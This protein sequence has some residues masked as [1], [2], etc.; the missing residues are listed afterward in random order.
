MRA[1]TPTSDDDSR[2]SGIRARSGAPAA[3]AHAAGPGAGG[4]APLQRAVGN[5]VVARMLQRAR[6]SS[7]HEVLRSPG[8]PLAG[9]V[10]QEME[11][12]LGADFSDVRVHTGSAA[13]ASAAEVGARAYTS[14]SHIVLGDGG[15]DRH[16]LA[17]E[18]THVVQQ[19]QGPVEGTDNGAGL[20]ISDPGDRFER[21]A[22]ANA[23]RVLAGPV[24]S[25]GDAPEHPARQDR[26]DRFPALQRKKNEKKQGP[27]GAPETQLYNVFF[28][29]VDQAV[30]WAYRYVTTAPQL[31]P[32]ADYDGHT[33]HWVEVWREFHATG[34]SGGVSKEFGYAVESVADAY[35]NGAGRPSLPGDAEFRSQVTFGTTRPDYVLYQRGQ[36]VGA[37]DVTATGSKDHTDDKTRWNELF[38]QHGESL[39]DSLDTNVRAGMALAHDNEAPLTQQEADALVQQAAEHRAMWEERWQEMADSFRNGMWVAGIM[40]SEGGLQ[41]VTDPVIRENKRRDAVLTWMTGEL[42]VDRD[43]AEK[44][45]TSMLSKFNPSWPVTFNCN[46]TSSSES[47]GEAFLS[48]VYHD[49]AKRAPRA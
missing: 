41:P 12:R 4:L 36:V 2:K 26:T 8:S 33:R 22:E 23:A 25:G 16:T 1:R 40:T 35:L 28:T 14:G 6:D 47:R 29:A 34:R 11:S 46:D 30:E 42:G 19:R 44:N 3:G 7:V 5:A 17:H 27:D 32:L 43:T 15:G 39:Y 18:L 10:R 31:G 38:Q 21:E 13:R 45:A 49:W 24:P 9:P 20:R 48:S 37:V